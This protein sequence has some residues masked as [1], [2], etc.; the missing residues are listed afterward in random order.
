MLS[1]TGALHNNTAYLRNQD[2][3]IVPG[4][5]TGIHSQFYRDRR[6]SSQLSC[7]NTLFFLNKEK[8]SK[9]STHLNRKNHTLYSQRKNYGYPKEFFWHF[10]PIFAK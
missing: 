5:K 8:G 6:L 10:M 4:S 2:A 9:Y 3:M 7:K 1:M